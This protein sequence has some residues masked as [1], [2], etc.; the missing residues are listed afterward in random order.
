MEELIRTNDPAL[1]AFVT[2]LLQGE[3]IDCFPVDVHMS[4]LEG[5]I[6]ILPR[7]I[8]VHRDDLAAARRVLRDNEIPLADG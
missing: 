1:F 6:G 3:Q 7:R 8:L 4:A 2:A 5:S